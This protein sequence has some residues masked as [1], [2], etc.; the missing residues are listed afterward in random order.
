MYSPQ[1]GLLFAARVSVSSRFLE[2][3]LE[4]LA[5]APFP[6]SPELEHDTLRGMSLVTFPLYEDQTSVLRDILAAHG[7]APSVLEVKALDLSN[8]DEDPSLEPARSREYPR[9]NSQG[10]ERG[11]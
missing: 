3:L 1:A 10:F 8:L 7:F 4:C 6:L 5:Q 9:G 11:L 2:D